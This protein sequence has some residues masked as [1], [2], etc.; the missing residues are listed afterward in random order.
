MANQSLQEEILDQLDQL[1]IEHQRQVLD[2]ARALAKPIGKP[3]KDL[4]YFAGGINAED[5]RLMAQTIEQGCE[6]I[7]T[8]E[9]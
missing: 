1:P 6:Q 8:D 7:N 3:G 2:F 5:L 9:W 4:L